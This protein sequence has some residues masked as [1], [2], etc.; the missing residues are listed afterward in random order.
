VRT[1]IEQFNRRDAARHATAIYG[2][3]LDHDEQKRRYVIKSLLRTEG[4][5]LAAYQR[6]FGSTATGDLPQLQ[7][8]FELGLVAED[9][10]FL[11]L[12]GDG[13][14]WSDTIGPWLY[15]DAMNARMSAYQLA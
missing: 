8:L 7:E 3:P 5:A 4:V 10:G 12:N 2:V 15:S 11:R 13:L 1:I 14:M 6:R 9:D